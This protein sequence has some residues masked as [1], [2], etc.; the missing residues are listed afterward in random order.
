[1]TNS[2]IKFTPKLLATTKNAGLA[3]YYAKLLSVVTTLELAY[4]PMYSEDTTLREWLIEGETIEED[5]SIG[6]CSSHVAHLSWYLHLLRLR[7]SPMVLEQLSSEDAGED[8]EPVDG[9]YN[10]HPDVPAFNELMESVWGEL[11]DALSGLEDWIKQLDDVSCLS[12]LEDLRLPALFK[13]KK[14]TAVLISLNTE[15]WWATNVLTS[16]DNLRLMQ[17][18]F[19]QCLIHDI[20][21]LEKYM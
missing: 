9:H 6:N 21:Q 16:D 11:I 8:G 18:L 20:D 13:D 15:Q 10:Q 17:V 7:P 19:L 12:Q 14:R 4:L 5:I 1:M 2:I 3:S